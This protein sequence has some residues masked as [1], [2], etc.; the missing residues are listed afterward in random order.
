LWY[1]HGKK[2]RDNDEP[3]VICLDGTREWHKHDKR[4]RETGPARIGSDGTQEWWIGGTQVSE[5]DYPR[6]LL[7]W[8]V[9][10]VHEM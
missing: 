3:A 1:Q 9:R 2:H 8:K 7:E 4:H 6:A 10:Q 5:A